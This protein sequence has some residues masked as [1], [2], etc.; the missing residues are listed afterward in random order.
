MNTVTIQQT[1]VE[2]R[3]WTFSFDDFKVLCGE[4]DDL[5]LL[6]EAEQQ[7]IWTGLTSRSRKVSLPKRE[8]RTDDLPADD[9]ETKLLSMAA[10]LIPKK[11]TK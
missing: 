7:A 3:V 4:D 1:I 8:W 10:K 5:K 6:T 2:T 9:A 11:K